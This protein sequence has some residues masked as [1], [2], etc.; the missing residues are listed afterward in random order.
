[1]VIILKGKQDMKL[2]GRCIEMLEMMEEE[3]G[4]NML[5][6]LYTHE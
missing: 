3:S 5:Q 1:M 2:S 4:V 6:T